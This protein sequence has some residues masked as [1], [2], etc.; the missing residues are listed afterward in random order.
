MSQPKSLFALGR[1]VALCGP[2]VLAFCLLQNPVTAEEPAF[3]INKTK[4]GLQIRVQHSSPLSAVL[5]EVCR[6]SNTKCDGVSYVAS[7]IVTPVLITGSW[8]EVINI[9]MTGTGVNYLATQPGNG[10]AGQLILQPRSAA[11]NQSVAGIVNYNHSVPV[12][13]Q[14]TSS[15]QPEPTVEP[16][17]AV[18][19]ESEVS[20]QAM[21]PVTAV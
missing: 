14:E 12:P 6:V 18:A 15:L 16:A 8:A 4:T 19:Q 9:L 20:Q 21:N 7:D 11:E 1:T 13:H 5:T 3:S 10:V 2:V 17:V